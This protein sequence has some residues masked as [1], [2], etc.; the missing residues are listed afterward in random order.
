LRPEIRSGSIPDDLAKVII[1]AK[2]KKQYAER[3]K[4][5]RE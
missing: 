2:E 4:V 1:E 5:E 3:I